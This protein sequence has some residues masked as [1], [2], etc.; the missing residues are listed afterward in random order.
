MVRI[1]VQDV[2]EQQGRFR[3]TVEFKDKQR[4]VSVAILGYGV[5]RTRDKDSSASL[6]QLER[7]GR[8]GKPQLV[9]AHRG[10]GTAHVQTGLGYS[11]CTQSVFFCF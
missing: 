4:W 6:L 5:E 9:A 1:S 10:V 2:L 11:Q 7:V 3:F 8:S